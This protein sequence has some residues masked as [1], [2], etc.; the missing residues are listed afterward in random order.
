[1]RIIGEPIWPGRSGVE[2]PACVQHEALINLAFAGRNVTILCPYDAANLDDAVL[3]DAY[4]THPLVIDERGTRR[5]HRYDPDRV[6]AD[7]N[8]PLTEPPADA[9]VIS[10]SQ[11]GI[12]AVRGFVTEGARGLGLSTER[13]DDLV[14][15]VNELTTNSV[16]HGGGSGIVRLWREPGRLVCETW[17][18]GRLR[19]PLAG[20][21]PVPV[22]GE[23][24][25]GLLL[26]NHL[27]D[28]VRI[29]G[30]DGGTTIR[31]HF[32]L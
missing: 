31:L 27:S 3:A 22:H 1:V 26:V 14:L 28:L 21:R 16:I 29:H 20:R 23:E 10:F 9:A 8:A 25:R 5:S 30:T 24:G 17:D 15:A 7:A 19:D 11:A 32:A 18:T 4:L 6:V 12:S 13:I 2:Y